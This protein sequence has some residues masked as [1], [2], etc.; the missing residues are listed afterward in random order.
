MIPHVQR[1]VRIDERVAVIDEKIENAKL[2]VRDLNP[3][4]RGPA[5]KK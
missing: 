2:K 3:A 4:D 5:M 1:V